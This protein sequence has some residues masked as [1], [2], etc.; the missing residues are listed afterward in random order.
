M[1]DQSTCVDPTDDST[2]GPNKDKTEPCLGPKSGEPFLSVYSCEYIRSPKPTRFARAMKQ[3]YRTSYVYSHFV[4]YST[5]TA[6]IAITYAEF[7]M[8]KKAHTTGDRK[9]AA[10]AAVY[11]ASA[12][13]RRWEEESPELFM[14]E[15]TQGALVHAR[16]VLPHETRRQTAECY[17]KSKFNCMVGYLCDDAVPFV[18]AVHQNN[19]FQNPNNGT[20][21]NCWRN[22]VIDETLVPLLAKRMNEWAALINK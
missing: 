4:H 12:H 1:E 20:Y 17:L 6:D 16:S 14:D 19:V 3:I 11:V 22:R 7:K 9:S 5:V 18:D 8:K 21:C 15:Q 13:G 2:K 10:R